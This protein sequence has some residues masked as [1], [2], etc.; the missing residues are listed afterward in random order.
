[1]FIVKQVADVHMRHGLASDLGI[2][3]ICLSYSV[4]RKEASSSSAIV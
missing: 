2:F 1:M 4:A 3:S